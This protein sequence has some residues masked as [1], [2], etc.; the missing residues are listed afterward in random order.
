MWSHPP[1]HMDERLEHLIIQPRLKRL[2]PHPSR[3]RVPDDLVE[4]K[5]GCAGDHQLG[6]R[7][8]HTWETATPPDCAD[9][10]SN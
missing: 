2:P 1:G 10:T 5:T 4:I 9:G 3:R 8:W 6:S 7:T